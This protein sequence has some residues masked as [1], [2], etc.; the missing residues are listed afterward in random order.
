MLRLREFISRTRTRESESDREKE[1]EGGGGREERKER[2]RE[3]NNIS[4]IIEEALTSMAFKIHTT[5]AQ[6]EREKERNFA[7]PYIIG[8]QPVIVEGIHNVLAPAQRGCVIRVS[9]NELT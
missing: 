9:W 3:R 2:E 8:L 1:R 4:G 6:K 7:V 5:A